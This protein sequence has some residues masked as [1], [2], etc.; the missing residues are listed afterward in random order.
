M[1]EKIKVNQQIPL[2]HELAITQRTRLKSR[3]PPLA[4]GKMLYDDGFCMDQAWQESWRECQR[5]SPL[6][7]FAGMTCPKEELN[8][9]RKSLCNLNRLRTGHGRCKSCMFKWGLAEDESCECGHDKQ[10]T[11]HILK[12]CPILA[13]QGNI[14]DICNLNSDAKLWLHNLN[15]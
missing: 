8:L 9:P 13:Y 1:Y 14:S 10:T 5:E 6:F 2:H 3:K 4:L 11:E 15:L 7:K 12:H